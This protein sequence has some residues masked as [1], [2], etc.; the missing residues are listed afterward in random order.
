MFSFERLGAGEEAAV[1]AQ[2]LAHHAEQLAAFVHGAPERLDA[3]RERGG[4]GK[5]L[6]LE[7]LGE[8][9]LGQKAH[10]LGEHGEQ[11]AHEEL[12]HQHL[13]VAVVFQL[14]GQCGEV[15]RPPRA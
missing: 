5:P 6:L 10:V 13:I 7:R 4:V 8:D 2:D 3:A 11:T 12:R 1:E 15:R 14:L 9:A